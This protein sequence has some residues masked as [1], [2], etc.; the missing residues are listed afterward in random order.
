MSV[1]DRRAWQGQVAD[2]MDIES[3]RN[4]E[5]PGTS[6]YVQVDTFGDT[7][8]TSPGNTMQWN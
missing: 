7:K 2:F 8:V 6:E 5:N 1:G 3:V 4:V